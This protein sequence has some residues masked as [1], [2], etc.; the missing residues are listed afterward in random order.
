M[1]PYVVARAV[2]PHQGLARFAAWAVL[3]LTALVMLGLPGVAGAS[4]E[5]EAE[6]LERIN[7]TRAEAGV[8]PLTLRA[9][10]S[11]V[12]RDHSRAMAAAGE[13]SHLLDGDLEI[14]G[15]Q[16]VSENTGYGWSVRSVHEMLVASGVHRAN[17]LDPEPTDIGIG[18]AL[19]DG[20]VWV[21]QLFSEP[22]TAD[23][24]VDT[25]GWRFT[26][27]P[28]D[29]THATAIERLADTG[30]T[31]GC[32]DGRF[33][34][35]D[36]VT[37]GQFAS[38][39]T[40][41]AE[42]PAAPPAPFVDVSGVH[43]ESIGALVQAGITGGCPATDDERFCPDDPVTRAQAATFLV[44]AL[45]LSPTG[46]HPFRDVSPPHGDNVGA[47]AAAGIVQGC[48]EVRYCPDES[49]TRGQAASLLV[50]AF[51]P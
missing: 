4:V 22:G 50:A 28:P 20:Q 13:L 5:H 19:H 43:A 18:V 10:L 48:T 45:D 31:G 7:A 51:D 8:G 49:V 17:L 33:C 37:R 30:I 12:A 14:G 36:A 41:A 24:A 23:L 25:T 2:R 39:L 42:L 35:H 26:D 46:D 40:A 15:W 29:T 34:P 27:V 32:G 11:E 21:T 9:G 44:R 16:P 47:L 6:F 1:V 38:L 3:G